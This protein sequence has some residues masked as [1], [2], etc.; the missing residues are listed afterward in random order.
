MAKQ[1]TLGKNERLKSSK[2]IEQLFTQGQRLGMFPFQVRYL[3]T[4]T[5]P[6]APA[7]ALQCGVTVSTRNFKKAV[8]R[9]RIK[10]LLREAWRLQKNE[11]QEQVA[12]R[13]DSLLVFLIYTGKELPAFSL[14]KEKVGLIIQKL[15]QIHHESI[16]AGA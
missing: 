14:V 2:G 13:P 6:Q 4:A 3:F 5:L 1:F 9:N 12:G 11:L 8:H 15:I 10:R 7:G 16:A